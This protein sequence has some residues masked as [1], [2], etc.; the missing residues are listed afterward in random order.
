MLPVIRPPQ[1]VVVLAVLEFEFL[2]SVLRFLLCIPEFC[3]PITKVMDKHLDARYDLE[4]GNEGFKDS[5]RRGC[6]RSEE[7]CQSNKPYKTV[8]SQKRKAVE[9]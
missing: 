3:S 4:C 1:N 9:K 2:V 5:G 7:P 6:R 8:R